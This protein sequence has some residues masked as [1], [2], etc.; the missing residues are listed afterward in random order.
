[1]EI[2]VAVAGCQISVHARAHSKR[3]EQFREEEQKVRN[4]IQCQHTQKVPHQQIKC[5]PGTGAKIRTMNRRHNV[6]ILIQE[7]QEF[8]QQPEETTEYAQNCTSHFIV[9]LLTF[10]INP[11]ENGAQEATNGNDE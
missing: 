5:I 10:L 6:G 11:F 2:V 7:P 3:D 8:F 9:V 1:M 4:F